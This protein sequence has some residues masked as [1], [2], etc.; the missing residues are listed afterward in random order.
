ML[1]GRGQ[2]TRSAL[3][4]G[5]TGTT[6]AVVEAAG[7]TNYALGAGWDDELAPSRAL[8]HRRVNG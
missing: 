3:G 5:A 8:R 6:P 2:R 1:C 4:Y 7:T